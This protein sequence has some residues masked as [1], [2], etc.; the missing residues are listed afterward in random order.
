MEEEDRRLNAQMYLFMDGNENLEELESF[1]LQ[2]FQTDDS[3]SNTPVSAKCEVLKPR[4]AVA[5]H[6]SK[7]IKVKGDSMA[8]GGSFEKK[9]MKNEWSCTNLIYYSGEATNQDHPRLLSHTVLIYEGYALHYGI[10]HLDFA[11]RDLTDA[12]IKILTERGYMNRLVE[13]NTFYIYIYP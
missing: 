7:E 2:I 12:L 5:K 4:V 10:L 13:Y 1:P 9:R 8:M 3:V 6:I 11:G